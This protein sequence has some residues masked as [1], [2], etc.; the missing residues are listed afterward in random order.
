VSPQGVSLQ[1]AGTDVPALQRDAPERLPLV[2]SCDV[3]CTWIYRHV[4]SAKAT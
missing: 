4:M 2:W 1:G 3:A